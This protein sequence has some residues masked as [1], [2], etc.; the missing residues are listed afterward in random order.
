MV[1]RDDSW[2]TGGVLHPQH[3][4]FYFYRSVFFDPNSNNARA[5]RLS[6]PLEQLQPRAPGIEYTL[7][8]QQPP[9]L[10]VIR[11]LFRHADGP[12]SA[13]APATTDLAYYYILDGNIYQAP[14]VHV[15]LS[16]RM[17]RCLY[18]IRIALEDLR[19]DLDPLLRGAEQQEQS[20]LERE[21]AV[22]REA[23]KRETAADRERARKVEAN[24]RHVLQAFEMPVPVAALAELDGAPVAAAGAAATD[25]QQQGAGPRAGLQE[26]PGLTSGVASMQH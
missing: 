19:Q 2:L 5:A 21:L 17:Q 25:P 10:Y 13:A 7:V 16:A 12:S 23:P 20:A 22:G 6:V 11:K 14:S 9:H 3:A 24:L 15:A 26:A 4:L 18:G 1:W 8:D